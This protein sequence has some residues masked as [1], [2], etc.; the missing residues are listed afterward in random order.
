MHTLIHKGTL[1]DISHHRYDLKVQKVKNCKDV[2][3]LGLS[4]KRKELHKTLKEE[5]PL[6]NITFE[7]NNG[8]STLLLPNEQAS[9]L[10]NSILNLLKDCSISE[11][12]THI[13]ES[14]NNSTE[15]F[16]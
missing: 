7:G 15:N 13:D 9:I 6:V 3:Q 12:T 5:V 16:G 1:R 4:H 8:H 2:Y 11:Q 14:I 10:A